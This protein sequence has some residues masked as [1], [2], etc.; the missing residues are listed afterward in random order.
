MTCARSVHNSP[1]PGEF[2][3]KIS[4]RTCS[5]QPSQFTY[6]VPAATFQ[7]PRINLDLIYALVILT[8]NTN[9][10]KYILFHR[11]PKPV[12]DSHFDLYFN[13]VS[14]ERVE[15]SVSLVEA[16][17]IECLSKNFKIYFYFL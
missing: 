5:D 15:R 14:L 4:P 3:Q 8:V 10:T 12:T 16:L 7:P 11:T 6:L 1:A 17:Y 13:K 2:H 9:K